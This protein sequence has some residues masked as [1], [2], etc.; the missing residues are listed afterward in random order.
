M[1]QFTSEQFLE[2]VSDFHVLLFISTM[3]MLPMKVWKNSIIF[4]IIY[5]CNYLL[6]VLN[7]WFLLW[8]IMKIKKFASPSFILHIAWIKTGIKKSPEKIPPIPINHSGS[9]RKIY[10]GKLKIF[11][12]LIVYG[13]CKK[14]KYYNRMTEKKSSPF[15]KCSYFVCKF[16]SHCLS[17]CTPVCLFVCLSVCMYVC[18]YVR[19]SL[20]FVRMHNNFWRS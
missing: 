2:A 5:Y 9:A 18:T 19:L 15:A 6:S 17:V 11:Y 7:F 13:V 14:I 4:I 8:L 16:P 1:Q 10:Q 12:F 3:D 20:K